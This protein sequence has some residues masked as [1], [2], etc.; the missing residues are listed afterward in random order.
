MSRNE[1]LNIVI[2]QALYSLNPLTGNPY[3]ADTLQVAD[4]QGQRR[5]QD[6]FQTISSS[7]G[8]TSY[9]IPYLPSTLLGLQ[10]Y[11]PTGPTGAT[12]ATGPT[13]LQ[14]STGSTGP[15]GTLTGPTG[16]T[17]PT[18]TS[19]TGVTGPTGVTGK[20]GPS[21]PTGL[22]GF[23]ATGPTGPV[24]ASG[25]TGRLGPTGSSTSNY[26]VL[27]IPLSGGNLDITNV[28]SSLPSSFGTYSS[29]LS[30]NT[31]ITITLNSKYSQLNPPFFIGVLMYYTTDASP[32]YIYINVKYGGITT[33]TVNVLLNANVS[34]MTLTLTN[35][36]SANFPSPTNDASGYSY[37]IIFNILN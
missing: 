16:K 8:V 32:Q 30:A 3:N 5:W 34:P 29:A 9:P 1:E 14:G 36:T 7:S 33:S 20:T 37:Y 21:G 28:A 19:F 13:G 2:Q 11:N 25:P 23:G 4:G 27:K 26:G 22:T 10:V 24:G 15:T 17:G 6:I 12:G 18:G 31:S 35:F